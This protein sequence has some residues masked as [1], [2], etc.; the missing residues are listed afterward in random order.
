[1]SIAQT[2]VSLEAF[3]DDD[4]EQSFAP[5]NYLEQNVYTHSFN[6]IADSELKNLVKTAIKSLNV[7]EAKILCAH[8]GV[9]TDQQ[10]TLQEIGAELNLTRER[11][12][13]IQVVA[14]NKIKMRYGEQLSSFM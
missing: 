5:I 12:R 9:A 14:L 3:D 4:D 11:V 8:F 6:S 2:S 1:L 7:R 10:M 13:Q